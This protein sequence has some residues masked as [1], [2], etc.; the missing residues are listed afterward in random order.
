MPKPNKKPRLT[1]RDLDVLRDAHAFG[2]VVPELIAPYRFAGKSS[3]AVTSTLRRLYGR[4]PRYLYLRPE[5]LDDRRVYYRLTPRGARAIGVSRS[6]ILRPGKQSLV[7]RYALCWFACSLEP[8]QRTLLDHAAVL[9]LLV[10][11]GRIPKHGFYLQKTEGEP[12]RLGLAIV[13]HGALPMRLVRKTV[14]IAERLIQ[15]PA[16][17]EFVLARR[18]TLS[19]LT[20]DERKREELDQALRRRLR[21][22]LR[23][24]LWQ[25]GIDARL[26]LP[27]VIETYTVPGLLPLIPHDHPKGSRQ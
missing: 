3:A 17:R 13:D 16:T 25:H 26:Q 24:L 5:P 2:L 15:T 4:P 20:F 1:R 6:A 10:E 18:L 19:L 11:P 8:H 9:Q 7:R 27:F 22:Q 23:T 14:K 12:S 21:R